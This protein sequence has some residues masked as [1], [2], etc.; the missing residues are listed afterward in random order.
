LSPRKFCTGLRDYRMHP[1]DPKIASPPNAIAYS[2]EDAATVTGR[3]RSRI[4][5]AIKNKELTARKDGKATLLEADELRR[6]VRSLPT[7]GRQP[8]AA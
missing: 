5:K 7:I 8:V 6:W 3:S 2:P 4:F 1:M